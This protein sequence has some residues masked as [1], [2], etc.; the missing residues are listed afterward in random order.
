M[1]RTLLI[2]AVLALTACLDVISPGE[3]RTLRDA[4]RK[5]DRAN[6]TNYTYE[7]RTGCFCPPEIHEWAIVR[8]RDRQVVSAT[9]LDG[10]PLAGFDLA[11]RLTVEEL[12]GIAHS[13]HDWLDD[14]DF[15]FNEELGYPVRIELISKR[16]IADA[17]AVYEARNLT[18]E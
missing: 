2:P 10:T 1:R 13:R 15:D 6:I 9:T 18:P 16:N 4:E 17:G 11:S 12:F 8:V 3:E 14:I 7:M 5:W